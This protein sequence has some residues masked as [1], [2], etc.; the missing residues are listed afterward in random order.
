MDY[1]CH[2][3]GTG[4]SLLEELTKSSFDLLM[5]DW[6]LPDITGDKILKWVRENIGWALP[7]VFVTGHDATE[8]IV[9]M[10]ETGADD[11]MTK[12]INL[13]EMLARI[14]ALVRRSQLPEVDNDVLEIDTFVLDYKHHRFT[15]SDVEVNLTRKEF[16]LAAYLFEHVGQLISREKLLMKI[17]GYGPEI[18]TRTIDIHISRI[19]KKLSLIEENGWK[20]TS[21]Y[22]K[23][24]RLDQVVH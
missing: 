2:I 10:L 15:M 12:P 8:D 9:A 22:H 1:E 17:W 7:V 5:I 20:L 11:Y 13:K 16:E 3:Y 24:Y 19:R 14:T 4:E 23:G 21:I 18:T 6:E